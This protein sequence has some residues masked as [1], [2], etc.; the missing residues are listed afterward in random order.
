MLEEILKDPMVQTLLQNTTLCIF[1]VCI[2]IMIG[3]LV[4]K[5]LYHTCAIVIILF[6]SALRG[7]RYIF[8]RYENEIQRW[9]YEDFMGLFAPKKK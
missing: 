5:L 3:L 9:Y 4:G 8:R 7:V 2:L 1:I 6:K